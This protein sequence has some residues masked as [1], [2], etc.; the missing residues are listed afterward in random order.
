[1]ENTKEIKNNEKN[2]FSIT[3]LILGIISLCIN[4]FM[5]L[6]TLITAI[7]AIIFGIIGVIKKSNKK[8]G[9]AGIICGGIALLIL[10]IYFYYMSYMVSKNLI[11]GLKERF[12]K[13]F[14]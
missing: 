8:F 4:C 12:I 5:P 14:Y 11:T 1:M 9:I 13:L 3:A 2:G 6:L 7:M 10:T